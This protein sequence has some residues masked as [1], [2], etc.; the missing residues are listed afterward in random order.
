ARARL[1][2]GAILDILEFSDTIGG[3]TSSISGRCAVFRSFSVFFP[4]DSSLRHHQNFR[5]ANEIVSSC[6][7]NEEP[8]Y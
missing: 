8:V 1:L 6:G 3:D 2:K 7:E 5:G 4:P